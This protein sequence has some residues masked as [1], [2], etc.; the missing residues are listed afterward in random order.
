MRMELPPLARVTLGTLLLFFGS[1]LL[2][3][4]FI[5]LVLTRAFPR[6]R[7]RTTRAR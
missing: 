3:F 4:T 5:F 1:A 2:V 7:S 6:A